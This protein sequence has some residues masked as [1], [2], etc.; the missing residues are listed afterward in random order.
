MSALVK[1]RLADLTS[2]G[3]FGDAGG[4]GE[5]YISGTQNGLNNA[6]TVLTS[7]VGGNGS[8]TVVIQRG[9]AQPNLTAGMTKEKG[10]WLAFDLAS[11]G[12]PAA[13]V[14]SAKPNC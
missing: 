1:T 2:K 4:C 14:F 10:A 5:E 11:G 12:G 6:P 13:S 9:P 7:V 8:V 3:Y